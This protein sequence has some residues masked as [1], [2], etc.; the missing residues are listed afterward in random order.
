MDSKKKHRKK[1]EQI[2]Q[3][4]LPLKR[5]P[6]TTSK[7][8]DPST[9]KTLYRFREQKKNTEKVMSIS[10]LESYKPQRDFTT[11]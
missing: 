5:N 4:H 6:S 7:F 11:I 2:Q 1:N 3:A 9:L 10:K 8:V